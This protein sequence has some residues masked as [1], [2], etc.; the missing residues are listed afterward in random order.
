MH[1]FKVKRD[2]WHYRFLTSSFGGDHY[3]YEIERWNFCKYWRTLVFQVLQ[4]LF[5]GAAALF[6]TVGVGASFL[7][8]TIG[9]ERTI[10]LPFLS[11]VVGLFFYVVFFILVILIVAPIMFIAEK[12]NARESKSRNKVYE[13]GLLMVKYRSWKEKFCPDI[14]VE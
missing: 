7:I 14:E 3:Q 10:W 1:T 6:L 8:E 11:L 4:I 13:P 12:R 5:F 2:S 9:M